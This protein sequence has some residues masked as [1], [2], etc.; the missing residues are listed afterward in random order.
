MLRKEMRTKIIG[1]APHHY[2]IL[3]GM[4]HN[5]WGVVPIIEMLKEVEILWMGS[6]PLHASHISSKKLLC[7][8]GALPIAFAHVNQKSCSIDGE[9][10]LCGTSS[11]WLSASC[12]FFSLSAIPWFGTN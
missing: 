2:S 7:T 1:S 12:K 11:N 9:R 3:G 4:E 6:A 5:G 8:W 10:S